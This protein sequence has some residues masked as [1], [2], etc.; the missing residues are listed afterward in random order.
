MGTMVPRMLHV[1]IMPTVYTWKGRAFCTRGGIH[2]IIAHRCAVRHLMRSVAQAQYTTSILATQTWKCI[3]TS[4]RIWT[5]CA[6]EHYR[7]IGHLMMC[8]IEAEDHSI[9]H[10]TH[11]RLKQL[12][13]N[14]H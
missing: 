7:L 5:H 12:T 8:I 9:V 3:A 10:V 4:A 13:T 2:C 14:A 6:I 1:T 11:L